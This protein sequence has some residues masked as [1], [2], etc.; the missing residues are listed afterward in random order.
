MI[1]QL[2]LYSFFSVALVLGLLTYRNL[3]HRQLETLLVLH[4]TQ[5]IRGA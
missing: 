5:H 2:Y 1:T 4:V 3:Y